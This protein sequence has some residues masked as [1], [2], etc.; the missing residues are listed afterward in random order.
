ML[1]TSVNNKKAILK[2]T[3]CKLRVCV[4]STSVVPNPGVNTPKRVQGKSLRGHKMREGK[5]QTKN[6]SVTRTYGVFFT[7]L[8]DVCLLNAEYFHSFTES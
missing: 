7:L 8:C 3:L 4:S 1:A 5:R 2:A 6:I